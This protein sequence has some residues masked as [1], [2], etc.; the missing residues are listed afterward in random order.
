M[1]DQFTWLFETVSAVNTDECILWPFGKFKSGYGQVHIANRI[2]TQNYAHRISYG[3]VRGEIPKGMFVCHRCDTPACI[4]PWHLFLGTVQ[5]NNR[6]ADLKG[7][8]P[9]GEG[10]WKTVLSNA[11]VKEI[12]TLYSSGGFTQQSLADKFGVHNVTIHGIVSGK[13]RRY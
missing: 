4:N 13:E 11:Q 10:H 7:R 8:R 1:P 3:L 12:R 2:P 9:H 6:D 5:D